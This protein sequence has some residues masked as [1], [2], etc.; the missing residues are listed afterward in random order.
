ML[1]V[2]ATSFLTDTEMRIKGLAITP[3]IYY[4]SEPLFRALNC[5]TGHI[6]PVMTLGKLQGNV[7]RAPGYPFLA[8][9]LP[10]QQGIRM[11]VVKWRTELKITLCPCADIR[12]PK[13]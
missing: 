5:R 2:W 6:L 13:I 7:S 8:S 1:H 11:K 10:V 12:M 4:G 3:L 9:S